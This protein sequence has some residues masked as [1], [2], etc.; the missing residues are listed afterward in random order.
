MNASLCVSPGT[1]AQR[2][3]SVCTPA[4]SVQRTVAPSSRT[5]FLTQSMGPLYFSVAASNPFCI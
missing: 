2:R 4:Q 3:Q 5:I 1:I